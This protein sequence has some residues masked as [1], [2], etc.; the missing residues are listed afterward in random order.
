MRQN[1]MLNSS[2]VVIFVLL[3]SLNLLICLSRWHDSVW[4]V[5]ALVNFHLWKDQILITKL[6]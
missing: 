6:L 1:K 3:I 4:Y 5:P 2:G